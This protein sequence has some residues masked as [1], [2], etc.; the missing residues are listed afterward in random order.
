MPHIHVTLRGKFPFI[1]GDSF[2]LLAED[3]APRRA[4]I[5]IHGY[6]GHPFRTW[7]QMQ[8][9][10]GE[11][12]R[13]RD[14]DAYFVGYSSTGDEI[15]LNASYLANF[16]REICPQPPEELFSVRVRG[17]SS[18]HLRDPAA[19]RYKAI[20]FFGHSLGAVV[21]RACVLEL[22]RNGLSTLPML[23]SDIAN[24]AEEFALPCMSVVRLFAPAQGGVRL[25]GWK[26]VLASSFLA[27]PFVAMYRG[28]SPS[29]Q[30]LT[31]GSP[32]LNA[33][34]E[35]SNYFAGEYPSLSGLRAQIAWAHDDTVVSKLPF[36]YD[37]GQTHLKTTH[38][39][40]CK[41]AKDS[42]KAFVFA[43]QG[44]VERKDWAI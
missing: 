36:R 41:P 35:D 42:P 40:V 34:R 37:S 27:K 7:S 4:A 22:L 3:P 26:G 17:G 25:S 16:V 28:K 15:G 32:M 10:I 24:M 44:A 31:P 21:L 6:G 2:A 11:D 29:F 23:E 13:W 9:M 19:T 33:L 20:D 38:Q 5:F 1:S 43:T 39:N 18:L 12:E 30:E 14:A 8:Q